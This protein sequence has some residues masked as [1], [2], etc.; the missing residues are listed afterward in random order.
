MRIIGRPPRGER[1]DQRAQYGDERRRPRR[2][3]RVR[4]RLVHV[5][6]FADL[7]LQRVHALL[8]APVVP[9]DPA[10]LKRPFTACVKPCA[11]FST[12]SARAWS[13]G[14]A[15]APSA[16]PRLRSGNFPAKK[17]GTSL[18]IECPSSSTA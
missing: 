13:A 8:R 4:R 6:G 16:V 14:A 17:R 12:V 18:R 11:P 15:L 3:P 9:R 2:V 10:A 7:E 1:R 5:A